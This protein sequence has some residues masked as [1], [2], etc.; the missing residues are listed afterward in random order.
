MPCLYKNPRQ[1]PFQIW[2]F[3]EEIMLK[4]QQ[5]N[6][7]RHNGPVCNES[8]GMGVFPKC[9]LFWYHIKHTNTRDKAKDKTLVFLGH[10][11]ENKRFI[12]S[13]PRARD[14]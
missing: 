1:K 5:K 6:E 3:I 14:K 2:N 7:M 4:N 10:E 11:A 9:K 8:S 12:K 13:A